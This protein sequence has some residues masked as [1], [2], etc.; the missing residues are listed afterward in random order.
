MKKVPSRFKQDGT[1]LLYITPYLYF[2]IPVE[3]VFCL[4]LKSSR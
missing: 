2:S 1:F 4:P 3:K